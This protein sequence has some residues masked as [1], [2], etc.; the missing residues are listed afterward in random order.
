MDDDDLLEILNEAADAIAAVLAP[1][2]DWGLAGTRA[3]QYHSDLAADAAAVALLTGAGLGVLSEESGLHHDDRA[4]LVALDPVDGSTNASHRLPW[5]ATSLCALDSAGARAAVVVNQSSGVRYEAVRGAGATRDGQK[6]R[7]SRSTHLPAAL[8]GLSGFPPGHFGW[9]QFRALGAAALDICA[10]A[11]GMLD[12]YVDCSPH[13][14]APWDYL[15]AML[16]CQEAG[17]VVADAHGRDL[18][19][20]GWS[21]RRTPVAAGTPELLAQLLAARSTFD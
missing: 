3:G 21:E 16:V 4:L 15:G 18:I 13:A 17:A 14:H 7:P 1:L 2:E 9:G 20:R 19:A 12:A 6:I 5:Y 11:D 10:V 8:V